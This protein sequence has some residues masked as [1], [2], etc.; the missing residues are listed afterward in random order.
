MNSH[1]FAVPQGAIKRANDRRFDALRPLSFDTNVLKHAEGACLVAFGNT[2]VICTASVE[3]RVPPFLKGKK[4]GWV[5]AEYG[6]LPR[7][8]S[9]RCDREA[10]KGRQAG[11]TQEIQRLIGRA[12][13]AVCDMK[14]LGE[15]QIKID[16]DVLEAD[17]G[18][19]TAAITG[20]YVA[21]FNACVNLMKKKCVNR[22]PIIDQ[23]AAVSCGLLGGYAL[24]D[25][26][27]SEDSNAAVDANFVFT[28]SG[29]LVETQA[30]A[31]KKAFSE[32]QFLSLLQ[33]AK[34]GTKILFQEQKKA[35]TNS[36]YLSN[37]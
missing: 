18:T 29:L 25:L 24:L 26:D 16:C 37:M 17:G 35:V 5:T 8:T 28:K 13:R 31:E 33:L 22:F 36:S 7:A 21:L 2:K 32:E 11:R 30:C 12:L 1:G 34:K 27:F 23:V 4:E 9:T 14:A 15:R 10:A 3:D 6:M 20:S 19:R